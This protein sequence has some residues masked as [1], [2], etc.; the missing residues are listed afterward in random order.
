MDRNE[1]RTLWLSVGAALF[2]VFLLY[3]YT[4]EKNAAL[5]RKYVMQ[6]VVV[7]RE[8]INEME[9]IDESMLDISQ[10]PQEFVD[11]SAIADIRLA[12]GLVALAP[13]KKGEQI[14]ESKIMEPGPVTGLARQVSPGMRA[15]TLPIDDVRGVAKLIKPGDRIDLLASLDI[16]RGVNQRR[17]VKTIL[18][19]VSVLSTGIRIVNELPRVL[20]R[21][22][23]EDFIKNIRSDTNF[24]AITVEVSPQDAQNLVYILATSPG[25]LFATLRH[26]SDTLKRTD[27]TQTS[28]ESILQRADSPTVREQVR[29][30]AQATPPAAPRPQPAQRPQQPNPRQGRGFVDL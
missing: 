5:T 24:T 28:V 25:S 6:N 26:P 14:L 23:R 1:T 7:A 4:N 21:V 9:T 2:A 12:V 19:D 27:L 16:G 22:G 18:Q 29:R 30:P 20:E 11:P 15:I 10:R 8:D 17:E 3:S 13:I